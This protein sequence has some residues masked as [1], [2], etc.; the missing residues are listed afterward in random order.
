MIFPFRWFD[1]LAELEDTELR[2]M[3]AAIQTYAVTGEAPSFKGAMKALWNEIKQRIDSDRERYEH[4]CEVRRQA[5]A[6]GAEFGKLG[7]RPRKQHDEPQK[8]ANGVF[9]TPK[10]PK[11]PQKTPDAD[12]D[13]DLNIIQAVSLPNG[14]STASPEPEKSGSPGVAVKKDKKIFFDYEGDGKI[15]GITTDQ[16]ERWKEMFPAIDVQSELRSASAWLDGNRKNR[17]TDVK[18]FLTNWLIRHQDSAK[19]TPPA[20]RGKGA[21][22]YAKLN[23]DVK[24]MREERGSF[25]DNVDENGRPIE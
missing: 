14:K 17:K 20:P 9:E 3:L 6:K 19:S 2:A 24:R 23:D 22:D 18:R 25:W 1:T 12:A 8:T 21:I 7:G 4:I 16:L 13:A 5:G 10:N 15:H 11:K